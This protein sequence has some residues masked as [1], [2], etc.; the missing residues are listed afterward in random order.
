[1]QASSSIPFI[2]SLMTVTF[3]QLSAG[4]SLMAGSGH[5][6]IDTDSPLAEQLLK[7]T[8]GGRLR[9]GHNLKHHSRR[10]E[11]HSNMSSIYQQLLQYLNGRHEQRKQNVSNLP[12][13]GCTCLLDVHSY[14]GKFTQAVIKITLIFLGVWL[15]YAAMPLYRRVYQSLIKGRSTCDVYLLVSGNLEFHMKLGT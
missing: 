5:G 6:M 11:V 13:A 14:K 8:P 15:T 1:M 10:P 2:M 4:G 7:S 9:H 3:A 12:A